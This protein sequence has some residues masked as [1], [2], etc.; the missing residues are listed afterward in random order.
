MAEGSGW[1]KDALSFNNLVTSWPEI[2]D[3]ARTQKRS[4]QAQG[5]L[6]FDEDD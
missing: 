6:D 5:A 3:V 4:V 1:T 2:L